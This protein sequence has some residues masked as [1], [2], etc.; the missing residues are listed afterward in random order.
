MLETLGAEL[1]FSYHNAEL[2]LV[3][4]NDTDDINIV[5]AY[6]RFKF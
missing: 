4:A 2:D 3:G 1:Y 6:A 5:T